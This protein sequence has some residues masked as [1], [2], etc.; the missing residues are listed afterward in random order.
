MSKKIAFICSVESYKLSDAHMFK[1]LCL[2]PILLGEYLGYDVT[3]LTTEMNETL[4]K[5]TF[6]TVT[7]HHIP[8]EADYV[9][10]MNA[11]LIEHAQEID[12]AFAIGP[13]PSYLSILKTYKKFNPNGKIY[14]KL[15]V[16]R[17]WLSRLKTY[18]YFTELLQLCDVLTS[19]SESI[20]KSIQQFLNLDIKHIPNGFY[21]FFP[22]DPVS[23]SEKKNRILTVGRLDA[24]EK[25]ILL[26]VKAFLAAELTDWEYRLVGPMSE[27]F[28]KELHTLLEGSPFASKVTVL[29]PI[30]DKVQL[31]DEYRQAKIFCL[32]SLVECYAHVFAEAAKNGCYIVTT[33]VDGA[34]DITHHQRFG[35][36]H[37]THDWESVGRTLQ[38]VTKQDALLADTCAHLQ[39]FARAELNWKHIVQK[40][41]DYL[42][43]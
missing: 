8:F 21:E 41:A 29:G 22:T 6:P 18:P 34:A 32:T 31:E 3:I 43:E 25:Q 5:Q 39:A 36:I 17:F 15:D 35:T 9:A 26:A 14:M 13:Y 23:F 10:N 12:I 28:S 37:P 24:P 42:K 2:V 20:Q 7:F 19:E 4:L 16:N 40:V 38:Q 11:Y 1:D 33:D 27:D 30:Y